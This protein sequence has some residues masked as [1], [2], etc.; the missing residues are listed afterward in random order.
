[1]YQ[2]EQLNGCYFHHRDIHK[3]NNCHTLNVL[4]YHAGCPHPGTQTPLRSG[5]SGRG[6]GGGA[7]KMEADEQ[8]RL[9]AGALMVEALVAEVAKFQAIPT[10]VHP[11]PTSP[12]LKVTKTPLSYADA[13]QQQFQQAEGRQH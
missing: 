7:E 3:S 9:Q 4:F 5:G 11:P 10:S 12:T 8:A 1:M 2:N 13:A 6:L